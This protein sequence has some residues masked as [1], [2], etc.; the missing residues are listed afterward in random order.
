MTEE[1]RE[2]L[3]AAMYHIKFSNDPKE[4]VEAAKY[5]LR[6]DSD[7]S[8]VRRILNKL[9]TESLSANGN[10][11]TM[12]DAVDEAHKDFE[13]LFAELFVTAFR[14]GVM[15]VRNEFKVELDKLKEQQDDESIIGSPVENTES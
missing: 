4:V 1:Q 5:I 15:D 8:S 12:T 2:E 6:N 9:Q 10:Q 14:M 3:N 13:T 11:G 7:N